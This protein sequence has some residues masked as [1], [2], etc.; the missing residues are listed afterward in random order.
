M[1]LEAIE[2]GPLDSAYAQMK[3]SMMIERSF[4]PSF[5]LRLAAKDAR[6]VLEAASGDGNEPVLP[7]AVESHLAQANELG[8][9]DED[10]AAVYWAA[11]GEAAGDR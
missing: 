4:D 7:R 8:H 5:P 10:M 2:G 11:I 9:G 3:G 6:L 1:F